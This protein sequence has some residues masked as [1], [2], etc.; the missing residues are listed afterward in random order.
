M[1]KREDYVFTIGFDGDKAIVDKRARGRYGRLDARGLA[2]EGL[3]KEAYRRALYDG[4]EEAGAY[5]LEKFNAVSPV[6]YDNP[7]DLVKVFGIQPPGDVS[8][9]R[10]V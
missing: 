3:Y 6:P 2:D 10:A 8:A 9:V 4:D 1:M 5:V 7:D